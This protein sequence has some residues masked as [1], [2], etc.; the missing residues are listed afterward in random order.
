[1][2]KQVC[3]TAL[4]LL[5][6][7]GCMIQKE[8]STPPPGDRAA[9][10]LL[11]EIRRA[12][13]AP[14]GLPDNSTYNYI[15][16]QHML[17][18]LAAERC[19]YLPREEGLERLRGMLALIEKLER[20]HGFF[21]DEYDLATGKP[22]RD[23]IYFQGWW[24]YTLAIL[25]NAYPE[26]AP[27]CEKLLAEIDYEKS[28][29][30]NPKTRQL[31]ADY[32]A[33]KGTISYWIDLYVGSSGEMR[34]PYVAY[35]YLTGDIS[36]W[37]KKETPALMDIEGHPVLAVW[38]HFIF[39]TMLM[40][41]VF[42]DVGYFERSWDETLA[43]LEKYRQASGMSFFPTRAEPLESGAGTDLK[44]W[45][46][47]EHRIAKPWLAWFGS[48]DAPVLE[49]AWIPGYG[50]SLY[51]D[52]MNFYW[53]YGSN[54]L[55]V[56]VNIGG[57]DSV[58]LPFEARLPAPG[59][60]APH[61]A[62][63]TALQLRVSLADEDKRP[64]APLEILLNGRSIAQIR[65]EELSAEPRL[66]RRE[67]SE[68]RLMAHT[69]QLELA[70]RGAT[71]EQSYRLYRHENALWRAFARQAPS[72]AEETWTPISAPY[73]EIT[74]EGQHEGRENPFALLARCAVVHGYYPWHELRTD[75]RFLSNTVVWVGD[76]S[77]KARI[78][79]VVHN[80]SAKPV[81]VQYERPEEWTED[82][83]I[84]VMDLSQTT[85]QNIAF[86][87]TPSVIT[88]T[89]EPWHTYRIREIQ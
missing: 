34:A 64:A 12:Q 28:G 13:P 74:L 31:A 21:Y 45:P 86:E 22:R 85:P 39:C 48:E 24:I 10:L 84:E 1:M 68:G 71:R 62:R 25:K 41:S 16:A 30:W 4:L 23:Q 69:N 50:V 55:P 60:K 5:L 76:Y 3:G 77:A 70:S 73:V 81:E 63:L 53:S 72:G 2:N 61:P 56:E 40:H 47:T 59:L 37:T 11:E 87:A 17:A 18:L 46:N 65:P 57:A 80:T 43:G 7:C 33:D 82:A 66:V 9:I 20:R 8:P 6:G 52:N 75:P 44:E 78:G 36:P 15:W 58:V 67:I 35:T 54:T 14:Y 89:A 26:L 27:S 19:G 29:L 88:W 42:P 83:R 79:R 49:K 38:H 51:Y 32:Y